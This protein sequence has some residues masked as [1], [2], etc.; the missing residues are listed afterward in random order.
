MPDFPSDYRKAVNAAEA[1]YRALDDI[2]SARATA[3]SLRGHNGDTPIDTLGSNA[4][5]AWATINGYVNGNAT[6]QG[7]MGTVLLWETARNQNLSDAGSIQSDLQAANQ[8]YNAWEAVYDAA[9]AN[10]SL[11]TITSGKVDEKTGSQ[12]RTVLDANSVTTNLLNAMK[13]LAGRA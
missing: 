4:K 5:S 9:I 12:V 7:H 2:L 6:Q 3:S 11:Y 10:G 1:F 8:A 13:P